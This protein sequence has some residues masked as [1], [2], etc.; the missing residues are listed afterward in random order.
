VTALPPL[1]STGSTVKVKVIE[2]WVTK[3]IVGGFSGF[4]GISAAIT[5][6]SSEIG[7]SPTKLTAE[8]LNLYV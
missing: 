1:L 2:V 8:T 7:P 5:K 6:I 3:V 4:S